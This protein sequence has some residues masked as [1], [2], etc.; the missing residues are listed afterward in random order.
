MKDKIIYSTLAVLTIAVLFLFIKVYKTD[1][2]IAY[3]DT[4]KLME[5]SREM[6]LVRKQL[7]AEQLKIKNNIDTLSLEFQTALKDFEK[8]SSA[9]NS[10]EKELSAQLLKGKQEQL[11]QYKQAVDQKLLEEQNRKTTEALKAINTYIADYGAKNGFKMI[12][13]TSAG[14]IAF[15]D[16]GVDITEDILRGI[17]NQ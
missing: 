10:K 4:G 5:N 13:A 3:I 15:G 9:M 12:F 11:I 2:R 17:N 8:K 1:N 7:E 6:Q 14:N 16:K